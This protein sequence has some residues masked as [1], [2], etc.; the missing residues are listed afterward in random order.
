[1]EAEPKDTIVFFFTEDCA[2][3]HSRGELLL[4]CH[5][6][7]IQLGGANHTYYAPV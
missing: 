6:F 4:L 3:R 1:M 2:R 5:F 7:T